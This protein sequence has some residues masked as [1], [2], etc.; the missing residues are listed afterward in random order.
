MKRREFIIGLGAGFSLTLTRDLLFPSRAAWAFDSAAAP[1]KYFVLIKMSG[2]WDITL[3]LDPKIHSNGSTQDDMFI[4]YRPDEIVTKGAI[5]LAPAAAP[6]IPYMDK[7]AIINGIAMAPFDN[8]HIANLNYIVTGNGQGKAP[9]L[10]V[11]I[12]FAGQQGLMGVMSDSSISTLDRTVI[13]STFQNT[14]DLSKAVQFEKFAGYLNKLGGHKKF[15]DAFSGL[16]K[17]PTTRLAILA[18]L[19]KNQKRLDEIGPDFNRFLE[20]N[21]IVLA[22]AFCAGAAFQGEFDVTNN[23][24]THSGHEKVHLANQTKGW[25]NV[26]SIF[27]AFADTPSPTGVGS[28]FDQTTFMVVSEFSRTPALNTSKGKD[29]NPLTNS[30]LLAGRGIR[31]G[32]FGQSH[33]VKRSENQ[34]GMSAHAALPLNFMSGQIAQNRKQAEAAEFQYLAPENIART[35]AEIMDVDWRRFKSV[36]KDLGYLTQVLKP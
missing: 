21:A 33:L 13:T 10:P 23:L 16:A 14:I 11:E 20:R 34:Y 19:S 8:G 2:G 26:A 9:D 31:N 24:D 25:A 29:H 30:V 6:L 3:S 22:S 17:D 1:A 7:L 32:V 28:L 36:P 27:K 5:S 35:I 15:T 4:E 18:E 12:A